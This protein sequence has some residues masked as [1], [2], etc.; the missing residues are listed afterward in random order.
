[1]GRESAESASRIFRQGLRLSKAKFEYLLL[2]YVRF[3]LVGAEDQ[4]NSFA[5]GGFSVWE[6]TPENWPRFLGFS[7]P[8]THLSMYVGRNGQPVSG[9]WVASL[10]SGVTVDGQKWQQ[11]VAALYYLIFARSL[12]FRIALPK[13]DEFYFEFF[14]VPEGASPDSPHHVRYSKY[15][16]G[17]FSDLRIYPGPNVHMG[18]NTIALPGAG[19][20]GAADSEAID[21]F[22]SLDAEIQKT[23]SRLLTGL[24]FF[25]QASFRSESRSSYAEDV[26]NICTAFEALLG[27]EERGDTANK[28]AWKL[29]TLFTQTDG[30]VEDLWLDKPPSD[31]ATEVLDQLEK[32]VAALYDIRNRYTHGKPVS[33]WF[34]CGRSIWQ[35]TFEV[36][37]LA[38]NRILL[39]RPEPTSLD[40]TRLCSLLM[41][42]PYLE[43]FIR[44]FRS[45][46][47][48][49]EDMIAD[50]AQRARIRAILGNV[51]RIDPERVASISNLDHFERAL[52]SLCCLTYLSLKRVT[53]SSA[54][55]MTLCADR[56][57]GL[58]QA[59][60]T[61]ETESQSLH[62]PFNHLVYLGRAAPYMR[63]AGNIIP[64]MEDDLFLLD[65]TGPFESL[66]HLYQEFRREQANS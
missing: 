61:T 21:L 49:F 55:V 60:E 35:D 32:W 20:P 47:Q 30:T 19:H 2:P 54:E 26:Q 48:L 51:R 56:L 59:Y 53:Q 36:F 52:F 50:S 13:A 33:N 25:F 45:G 16:A 64:V 14:G 4:Q 58:E 38:A 11:L 42:I 44:T 12:P 5:F 1:M 63:T 23:E 40:G 28:V 17:M 46:R 31:E 8:D 66:F 62:C 3:T 18:G 27:V 37:V 39:K 15:G 29:R 41:S 24:T 22:Q 65:L 7:R 9:G 6:D 43:S 57:R 34:F 10:S